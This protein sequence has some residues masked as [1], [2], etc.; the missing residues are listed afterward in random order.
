MVNYLIDGQG[1]PHLRLIGVF[2]PSET[3]ARLCLACFK[4]ESGG[5][6]VPVGSRG[7]HSRRS[8]IYSSSFLLFNRK[9]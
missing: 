7:F 5:P 6:W 3:R 8:E 1:F 2:G 4:F 9:N